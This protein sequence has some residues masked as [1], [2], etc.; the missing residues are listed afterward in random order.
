MNLDQ[1]LGIARALIA[2][3]GGYFVGQGKMDP[4]QLEVVGGAVAAVIVAIWSF[5]AK[6]PAA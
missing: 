2:A 5:V 1:V 4:G 6:K 3:A